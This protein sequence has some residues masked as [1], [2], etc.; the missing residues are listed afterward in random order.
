M[1]LIFT[2][3]LKKTFELNSSREIMWKR[4]IRGL[5]ISQLQSHT[6]LNVFQTKLDTDTVNYGVITDIHF[7]ARA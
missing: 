2:V 7:C 3:S 1:T 4:G 5:T 6:S